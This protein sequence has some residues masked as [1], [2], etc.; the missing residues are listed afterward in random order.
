MVR[1]PYSIC[2]SIIPIEVDVTDVCKL[3]KWMTYD[4][5]TKKFS[6]RPYKSCS[7]DPK[8]YD[9]IM[10]DVSA[11]G[12]VSGKGA[13][14]FSNSPELPLSS[15]DTGSQ[16]KGS[17]ERRQP[18]KTRNSDVVKTDVAMLD[19]DPEK[20]PIKNAS[21]SL[22]IKPPRTNS[23]EKYYASDLFKLGKLH[24]FDHSEPKDPFKA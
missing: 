17:G 2:L 23:G 7:D 19:V 8:D 10:S 1:I 12:D 4:D 16:S 24:S 3:N 22:D 6:T 20:P 9:S 11:I 13:A 5:A 21:P 18:S 15:S 14:S